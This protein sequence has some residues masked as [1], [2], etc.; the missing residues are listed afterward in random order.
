MKTLLLISLLLSGCAGTS[1]TNAK[2][3]E[4]IQEMGCWLEGDRCVEEVD[5]Q[6]SPIESWDG[7]FRG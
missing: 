7:K 2:F 1:I 3:T 4:W 5:W 6:D